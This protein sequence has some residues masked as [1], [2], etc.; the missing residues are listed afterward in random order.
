MPLDEVAA[1][2]PAWMR[3]RRI[4]S[5]RARAVG[6]KRVEENREGGE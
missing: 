6:A 1:E 3:G 5:A 2:A 4:F